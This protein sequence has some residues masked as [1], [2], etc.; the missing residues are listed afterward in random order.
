MAANKYEAMIPWSRLKQ[1]IEEQLE[2]KRSL[3]ENSE[4]VE[5]ARLQG[6]VRTLRAMINLPNTLEALDFMEEGK[7]AIPH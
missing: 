3:F 5:A 7:D 6:D 1:H 4:G 2:A